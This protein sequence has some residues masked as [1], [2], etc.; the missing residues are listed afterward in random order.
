MAFRLK[1]PLMVKVRN[2][3]QTIQEGPEIVAF[4]ESQKSALVAAAAAGAPPIC[5]VAAPLGERFKSQMKVP[6]IRQF[7]GTAV[8]AVLEAEGFEVAQT[9]VRLAPG[10]IFKTGAVYRKAAAV[11]DEKEAHQR[12]LFAAMVKGLT[13]EEKKTL[14]EVVRTALGEA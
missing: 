2:W 7:V 4:V 6:A 14:F 1:I 8:K 10:T 9:G 11:R 3:S 12:E 13:A 5:V